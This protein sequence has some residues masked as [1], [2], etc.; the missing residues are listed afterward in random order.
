VAIGLGQCEVWK[1]YLLFNICMFSI[2]F[3]CVLI[4]LVT[5]VLFYCNNSRSITKNK[6]L[7][8]CF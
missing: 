6:N 2:L 8:I 5:T 3:V 4:F 1:V 7:E